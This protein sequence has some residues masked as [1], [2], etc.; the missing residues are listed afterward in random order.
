MLELSRWL[1]H[2]PWPRLERAPSGADCYLS[3]QRL[4]I[5]GPA[6]GDQLLCNEVQT[7]IVTVNSLVLASAFFQA[8]AGRKELCCSVWLSLG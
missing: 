6:S 7:V 5:I 1:K 8:A 2:P 4:A 3:H